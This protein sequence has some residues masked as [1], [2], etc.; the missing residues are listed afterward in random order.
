MKTAGLST[1]AVELPRD[2][3]E[4]IWDVASRKVKGGQSDQETKE[5]FLEMISGTVSSGTSLEL[6]VC[7]GHVTGLV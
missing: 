6:K 1:V 7:R 5:A 2:S 3:I 4:T